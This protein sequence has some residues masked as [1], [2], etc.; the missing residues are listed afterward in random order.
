MLLS[1]S[2]HAVEEAL[3]VK[4][5]RCRG[6]SVCRQLQCQGQS[7]TPILILQPKEKR[8]IPWPLLT[9]QSLYM[10][11]EWETSLVIPDQSLG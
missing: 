2:L 1:D 11:K 4:S 10:L 8:Q 3:E 5:C 6:L 7:D 9:T